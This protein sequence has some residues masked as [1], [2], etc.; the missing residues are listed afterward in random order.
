MTKD[1]CNYKFAKVKKKKRRKVFEDN[2]LLQV[3]K[4]SQMHW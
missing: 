2:P 1:F 4:Y 3:A